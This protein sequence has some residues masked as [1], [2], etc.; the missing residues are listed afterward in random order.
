MACTDPSCGAAKG[1]GRPKTGWL[2]L[3]ADFNGGG[4]DGRWYCG[5]GC[6]ADVVANELEKHH[7]PASDADAA[8][9]FD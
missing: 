1:R 6:L 4:R 8:S 3:E 2:K 9:L 5:W 7:I